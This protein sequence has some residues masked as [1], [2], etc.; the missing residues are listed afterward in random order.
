MN[1]QKHQ[2]TEALLRGMQPARLPGD[3]ARALVGIGQERLTWSDRLLATSAGMG[4]IA[5]CV[6][7]GIVCWQ[8]MTP[9]P[10]GPSAE[11]VA[12][13]QQMAAE[14]QTLIATR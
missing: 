8:M 14:Y 10:P 12:A 13:R 1:E 9:P 7:A 5:A 11:E 6:I 2:A 3:L 4:A